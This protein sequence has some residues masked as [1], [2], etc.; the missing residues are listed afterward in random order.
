[1]AQLAIPLMALGGFYV[2]ANHKKET[3][4]NDDK[5][6]DTNEAT[7]NDSTK[8]GFANKAVPN[9]PTVQPVNS[10]NVQHY[11]GSNQ[12]TDKYFDEGV[13]QRVSEN[14]PRESV[15]GGRLPQMSLTG[16][17]ID[18][19][20]FKHNNMVPFF[21]A[22][23]NGASLSSD[24]AETRLDN[25]Q[26]NGSQAFKKKEQA[27]LFKPQTNM[28]HSHGAPNMNDFLQSRVNPSM[29]MANIKP[30]KEE[31]V[32]PGLG[33][34]FT[35]EGGVGFNTGMEARDTWQPKTVDQLRVATNPK[36]SF[37][38]SG[39]EGPAN[40]VIKQSGNA[41]TQGRVENYAPDTYYALG[42]NRWNTTT[43]IEK[44]PTAR[45][46][47]VLQD[48]NRTETTEEYYG[49]GGVLEG[50]ATYAK[51]EYQESR[52]P[53]LKPN[54]VT[55]ISAVGKRGASSNDYGVSGFKPLPTNRS[56]VKQPD[57]FG[58]VQGVA[59]AAVAPLLD[60]LRP[61]RKE[62]VV[63]NIRSNGNAGTAVSN[64][65]IHDPSKRTKTTIRE[66]T[67]GAI[68]CNYLNVQGQDAEGYSVSAH[69]PTAVQR[70]T[71]NVQYTG[72]AGPSAQTANQSYDAAYR[73]RNN[74]NK[75]QV[76]RPNQGG[77]QIFNQQENIRI[78]RLD[79]DRNNNRMYAPSTGPSII[80]SRDNYGEINSPQ[81]YDSSINSERINPDILSAFKQNPYTQSLQSV[82]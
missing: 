59:R 72:G 42:P 64:A 24:I 45:G 50:Q 53:T 78:S 47:E 74:N 75:T 76:N 48:V 57:A 40:S 51:G 63:G 60:V 12:T 38:L 37:G 71:T 67:E 44:A 11:S 73:Q 69:Q 61:S 1:M 65:R 7:M 29:R 68:N 10:S 26:G 31:R 62:N 19:S 34:G 80:P 14:N 32:A 77:T 21:G 46:I 27:P 35:T 55:N 18:K 81:C 33:K 2:I 25:M 23:S 22:K 16:S 82:A 5:N 49:G 39:H 36:E 70:D 54:D 17:P 13:T 43:G 28:Q 41:Q 15:G 8:E 79:A 6:D 9:Y 20:N 66:M 56:T 52:R 58:G 30:W 3:L 4:T